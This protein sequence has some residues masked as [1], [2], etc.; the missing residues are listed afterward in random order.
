MK[1]KRKRALACN[2]LRA[3]IVFTLLI[4]YLLL[5]IIIINIFK[6]FV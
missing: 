1:Y 5:F 4:Y 6:E 3:R 2:L